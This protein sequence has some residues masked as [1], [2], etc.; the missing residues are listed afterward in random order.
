ML[1]KDSMYVSQD[2]QYTFSRKANWRLL[3]SAIIIGDRYECTQI[4]SVKKGKI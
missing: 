1:C 3:Y 4:H 2:I